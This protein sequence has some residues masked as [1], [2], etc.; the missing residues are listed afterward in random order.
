MGLIPLLEASWKFYRK[1]FRRILPFSIGTVGIGYFLAGI[2]SFALPSSFP[3]TSVLRLG[4]AGFS[5]LI[6]S[7]SFFLLT[8]ILSLLITYDPYDQESTSFPLSILLLFFRQRLLFLLKT[9]FLT[10]LLFFLPYG[11]IGILLLLLW[12]LLVPQPSNLWH[13]LFFL[14]LIGANIL[15][16]GLLV[17]LSG[18]PVLGATEK[19]ETSPYQI[20]RKSFSLTKPYWWRQLLVLIL[21]LLIPLILL[22]CFTFPLVL[23]E[24]LYPIKLGTVV[25]LLWQTLIITL[26]APFSSSLLTLFCLDLMK[27]T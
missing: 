6:L 15:L 2:F 5:L 10:F 8:A 13:Y 1:A 7:L 24:K 26:S 23:A 18:V 4:N 9:F 16:V 17:S 21:A 14:S 11:L 12:N 25:I 19:G 3:Q 22:G 20:L 27:R